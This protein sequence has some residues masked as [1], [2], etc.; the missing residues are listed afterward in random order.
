MPV[1]RC[2]RNT[3]GKKQVTGGHHFITG[4]DTDPVHQPLVPR[5]NLSHPKSYACFSGLIQVNYGPGWSKVHAAYL[6]ELS[7]E[8]SLHVSFAPYPSVHLNA[9]LCWRPV[10]PLIGLWTCGDRNSSCRPLLHPRSVS[11]SMT[12]CSSAAAC[13][14][15]KPGH[16][17]SWA[18]L[19]V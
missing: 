7:R 18:K 1:T 5:K 4:H 3:S 11:P 17:K 2:H 12:F 15:R 14:S 9:F 8:D 13:C 19:G 10:L 6:V 16:T